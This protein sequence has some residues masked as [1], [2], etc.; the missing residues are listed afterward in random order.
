MMS[1]RKTVLLLTATGLIAYTGFMVATLPAAFVWQMLPTGNKVSLSGLSGTLWSGQAR[2][3]IINHYP[4][5]I[6][7]PSLSWYWQPSALFTGSIT[8]DIHMGN[9][10]SALE[11]QG[12]ISYGFDGITLSNIQADTSASWLA[13]LSPQQLPGSLSGNISLTADHMTI[14]QGRCIDL[15]GTIQLT[16]SQF[17]S[18]FGSIDLGNTQAS[19][20]CQNSKLLANLNQES[21]AIETQAT[22]TLARNGHY[23]LSGTL[24]KGKEPNKKLEQ[25]L[26]LLGSPDADGRYPL[27]LEGRI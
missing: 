23:A 19:L 2:Q 9:L 16:G 1:R 17:S 6:Q 20:E 11:G 12:T 13:S 10:S 8:A 5:V 22:L 14:Q 3:I 25:G 21:S 26:K 15:D 27:K 4:E 18:A 24:S 7:L